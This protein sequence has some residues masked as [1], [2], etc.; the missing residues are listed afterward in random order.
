MKGMKKIWAVLMCLGMV[1]TAVCAGRMEVRAE[2]AVTYSLKVVNDEWRYQ[3]NYPWDDT[4]QHRELYYMQQALKDGDKLVVLE[5][6]KGLDLAVDKSLSNVT[7]QRGGSVV[8]TAP[9]IEELYALDGSYAAVN[10]DIGK[11][12]IYGKAAINFNKNV[13]YLEV[14]SAG[15]G[16]GLSA[17]VGCLGTVG[18]A[19]AYEGSHTVFDIYTVKAGTFSLVGGAFNIAEGN[20]SKTPSAEVTA[21]VQSA[22]AAPEEWD[23]VP[24]TGDTAG[25]YPLLLLAAICMLEGCR[26]LHKKEAVS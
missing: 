22:P 26:L 24:K 5:A 14:Y 18:H 1:C 7:L 17:S 21:P 9:Y 25:Y 4:V 13:Q 8:L 19:C 20:F 10:A 23:D 11:A 6:D 2:G 16:I 3:P 12:Y 15:D